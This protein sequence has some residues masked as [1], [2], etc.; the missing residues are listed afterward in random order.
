MTV[1]CRD[2]GASQ[3]TP[4]NPFP[5]PC[6]GFEE[7]RD[8]LFKKPGTGWQMVVDDEP[9]RD[10]PEHPDCWVWPVNF[11]AGQV[12]A[13]VTSPL[14]EG[15]R[16][17]FTLDVSPR[18]EK[19]GQTQF[20]E[21]I[22]EIRAHDPRLVI[23]SEPALS[24]IGNAGTCNDPWLAFFRLRNYGPQFVRALRAVAN[25]PRQVL[26]HTRRQVSLGQL[27]R[28]DARTAS[29]AARS[30][31]VAIFGPALGKV[32]DLRLDVPSTETT[33]DCAANRCLKALALACLQR[34][35]TLREQLD[36]SVR[37]EKASQTTTPLAARWPIRRA[38]L[39]SLET[40][41]LRLVRGYPF[42][43]ITTPGVSGAGL[44]AIDA[45][46]TY[47]RAWSRGWRAIRDGV[48]TSAE[49]DDTW[50]PPT[51]QVYERWCFV[52]LYRWMVAQHPSLEWRRERDRHEW[53]GIGSDLEIR[54]SLQPRFPAG[55]EPPRECW[56]VSRE[57]EP[58]I[59]V[60]VQRDTDVQFIVFDAKYRVTRQG[61][62]E[63]M[64]SAHIYQ[65]ALRVSG[66][67]PIASLLLVPRLGGVDWLEKP[68]FQAAHRVGV[69][70]L[71]P[72]VE[73]TPPPFIRAALSFVAQR[74]GAK[75]CAAETLERV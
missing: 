24:T 32:D 75:G 28:I 44:T 21:M 36:L 65:D 33:V 22:A 41:L 45:D 31:A 16:L 4:L 67:R 59:V 42:D 64:E 50:L 62:L 63:A 49:H 51:W 10:S 57:R 55:P 34:I 9:L 66:R 8:Y 30:S 15:V 73:F 72:D 27:R 43:E 58:D 5:E 69:C 52:A 38:E 7:D 53:T 20:A 19:L 39:E 61:V 60:T 40:Q 11:F 14:A 46:P 74:E 54:L 23:G 17:P 1:L 13:H 47:A 25:R 6:A 2:A 26:Q 18:L 37:S 48:D 71:S 56:S 29:V 12:R 3:W 70:Q 35:R 68:E